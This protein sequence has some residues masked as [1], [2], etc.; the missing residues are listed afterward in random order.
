MSQRGSLD[1]QSQKG[2]SYSRHPFTLRFIIPDDRV[3]QNRDLNAYSASGAENEILLY[4]I[5]R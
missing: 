1:R 2:N 3:R 4:F 5:R